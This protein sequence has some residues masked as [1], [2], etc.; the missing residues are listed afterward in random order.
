MK[1]VAQFLKVLADDARL[2]ILWLLYNH[3]EL[4][5]CDI[6]A[7]LRITQSK[8]SRHLA[9]L[10]HARLV[11]DRKE[12]A[13]SY[14]SMRPVE[15]ALERATLEALHSKLA[16]HPGAALVL[17]NLHAAMAES[18]RRAVCGAGGACSAIRKAPKPR[19][20]RSPAKRQG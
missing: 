2:Q 3:E 14:Y 7:A 6:M 12:A 20:K 8:A 10:R 13:W 18:K 1:D 17:R 16:D 11:V 19:P 15:G 5:V 4:C 9:T